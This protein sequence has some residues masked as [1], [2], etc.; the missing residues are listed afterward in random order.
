MEPHQVLEGKLT[1]DE[2]LPSLDLIR[3]FAILMILPANLPF[4]S[5]PSVLPQTTLSWSDKLV[6]ALTLPF[7]YGKFITILSI[8]FGTGLAIQAMKAQ[9]AGQPFESL[10]A[11]RMVVL[12]FIGLAHALLLWFG[13]ILTSYAIVGLLALLLSKLG[14]RALLWWIGSCLAWCYIW[15]LALTLFVALI[16]EEKLVPSETE[17]VGTVKMEQEGK[18]PKMPSTK[19]EPKAETETERAEQFGRAIER[20]F[21]QENQTRIYRQGTFSE[22]VLNN[23]I[24]AGFGTCCCFLPLLGWYLLACF[25]LGTYLFRQGVFYDVNAHRPL[26]YKF[27]VYGLAVG[28]VFN[29]MTVFVYLRN[30][31]GVLYWLL[32]GFGAL[33]TALGYMG[34]LL[35]WSQSELFKRLQARLIA[36]GRLALSNYLLQSVICT[37]IFYG[38]GLGLYGQLSQ[39]AAFALVPT[40]WLIQLFISPIWLQYFH[41]GPAEWLWRSLAEGRRRKFLKRTEVR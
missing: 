28:F 1:S 27:I 36:V 37:F 21:S 19:R 11:R 30:P 38:H 13:D 15:L 35:L 20:Y 29:L 34:L 17:S 4:F 22:R 14:Q 5:Q 32:V 24:F 2:R 3:G 23:A 6:F 33:P 39:S 40:I 31:N 12:F 26:I 7:V 9:V 16:G 8:L 25:L 10:Y 18:S 41:L